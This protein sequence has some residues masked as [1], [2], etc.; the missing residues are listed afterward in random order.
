MRVPYKIYNSCNISEGTPLETFNTGNDSV[1]L[2]SYGHNLFICGFPGHC[3]K[4]QKVDINV[5][6]VTATQSPASSSSHDDD[7]CPYC[8][9]KASPFMAS[10]ALIGLAMSLF[11]LSA[12]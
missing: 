9:N 8:S 2:N 4:G 1:K 3:Q 10:F 6:R 7:Q 11:A 5:I 12:F